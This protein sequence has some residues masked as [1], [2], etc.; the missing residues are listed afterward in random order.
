MRLKTVAAEESASRTVYAT[1]T[2]TAS[3]PKTAERSQSQQQHAT[4]RKVRQPLAHPK[5]VALISGA[6]LLFLG[7]LHY[8]SL[9]EAPTVPAAHVKP[10]VRERRGAIGGEAY[11]RAASELST[12]S[13]IYLDKQTLTDKRNLLAINATSLSLLHEGLGKDVG[14]FDNERVYTSALKRLLEAEYTVARADGKR[15]Q[16]IQAVVGMIQLDAASIRSVTNPEFLSLAHS[17]WRAILK[18]ERFT[19]SEAATIQAALESLLKA[20][21]DWESLANTRESMTLEV[22]QALI[23]GTTPRYS[24]GDVNPS[25]PLNWYNLADGS[26]LEQLRTSTERQGAILRYGTQGIVDAYT[27]YIAAMR[28]RA[29]VAT[30]EEAAKITLPPVP[31]LPHSDELAR[32]LEQLVKARQEWEAQ[33]AELKA[34]SVR[35][36]GE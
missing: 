30:P 14:F 12:P 9:N 35:V 17:E 28:A 5:R 2:V 22:L 32:G 21:P 6:F 7:S 16:A 27:P 19:T 31:A 26:L 3:V 34:I 11:L 33:R 36:E 29:L 25:K 8:L 4:Q 13:L 18:D 24:Y 15:A 23:T 10:I 20:E 1:P